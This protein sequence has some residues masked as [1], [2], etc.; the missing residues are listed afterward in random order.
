[1]KYLIHDFV[2]R[3]WLLSHVR[4]FATPW[5]VA[6]E[7]PLSVGFSRQE[8]GSGLPLPPPGDLSN[9]GTEPTSPASQAD[10][11]QSKPSGKR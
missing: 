5:T 3:E 9:P 11:L 7:A 4:L 1:M 6:H 8:Y 2:L 10:S